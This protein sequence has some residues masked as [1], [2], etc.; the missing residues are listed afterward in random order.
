MSKSEK[1]L[2]LPKEDRDTIRAALLSVDELSKSD[3]KAF[4]DY[5]KFMITPPRGKVEDFNE[6]HFKANF[7]RFAPHQQELIVKS[8]TSPLNQHLNALHNIVKN[9]ET[10]PNIEDVVELAK[11]YQTYAVNREHVLHFLSRPDVKYDVE[12][13][14]SVAFAGTKVTRLLERLTAKSNRRGGNVQTSSEGYLQQGQNFIRNPWQTIR[15]MT[16]MQILKWIAV[17]SFNAL[18]WTLEMAYDWGAWLRRIEGAQVVVNGMNFGVGQ[19]GLQAWEKY[20]ENS[21]VRR[22]LFHYFIGETVPVSHWW[23]WGSTWQLNGSLAYFHNWVTSTFATNI[24]EYGSL[25][26]SLL[27]SFI[28][29]TGL[30]SISIV[31]VLVVLDARYNKSFIRQKIWAAATDLAIYN[32]LFLTG[33]RAIKIAL[34]FRAGGNIGPAAREAYARIR[35]EEEY[36]KGLKHKPR[37]YSS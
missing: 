37:L 22:D 36:R 26:V 34:G 16:K 12:L 4:E 30:L 28:S 8:F 7:E 23:G 24:F 15:Q 6:K 18:R 21:P 19:I 29:V 2:A 10:N 35:F 25:C 1:C 27:Q 32:G 20:L 17:I 33:V 11:A 13:V 14:S 9:E 5:E 31:V 3:R